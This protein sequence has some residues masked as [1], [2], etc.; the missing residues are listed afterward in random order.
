MKIEKLSPLQI[1][2][3][4]EFRDRWIKIG[5]STEPADRPR[6][7]RAIVLD[8]RLVEQ[9]GDSVGASVWASVRASV[10]A[11]VWASVGDSVR[12]SVGGSVY[13]A[14]DANWL[15][16]Y[17]YF[18]EVCGLLEQTERLAGLT[19][20]A[21]SAG[22]A[23]PHAGIC[24]VSERHHVLSRDDRGR[25][26]SIAGPAVAYPDGW[27]IYAVRGVRVPAEWIEQKDKLDPATA[28]TWPNVEQR[29]AAAEIIGWARILEQ[30]KPSTIDT[31]R[32]PEIGTLLRVDLPDA[33]NSR[34]LRVRCG[35]GR[36][37]V[38]PVPAEM[39]TARQANAW[40]Y[41]LKPDEY[42]PEIRT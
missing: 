26:H 6:A 7:E 16:F 18:R 35:T 41:G 38:L 42:K 4:A 29:N 22:W 8:R 31:D 19:E 12:A 34:F 15:A 23:L 9:I 30:L 24:W 27:A 5:L 37:F 10:R 2:R 21:Q 40:T 11:S 3:M 25:L 36:E 1:A 14:H 32:D 17:A 33:P 20:L 39:E 13:G 28:L